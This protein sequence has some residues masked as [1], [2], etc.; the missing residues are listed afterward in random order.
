MKKIAFLFIIIPVF[1]Y[2]QCPGATAISYKNKARNLG[3]QEFSKQ[4]AYIQL[5]TYY[6]YKCEC[7]NG[8]PRSAQLV[9]MINSLVDTYSAYTKN[10]Y[11]T[12]SKVSSCKSQDGSGNSGATGDTGNPNASNHGSGIII[13][14][15]KTFLEE[16]SEDIGLDSN[17]IQLMLEGKNDEALKLMNRNANVSRIAEGFGG[18]E[19][20]A[21]QLYDGMQMTFDAI[22]EK[23]EKNAQEFVDYTNQ[24]KISNNNTSNSNKFEYRS[25]FFDKNWKF[26]KNDFIQ[27]SE[28]DSLKIS[29]NIKKEIKKL[30]L[31]TNDFIFAEFS[32]KNFDFFKDFIIEFQIGFNTEEV[33]RAI[34]ARPSLAFFISQKTKASLGFIN[35]SDILYSFTPRMNIHYGMNR[36][37]KMKDQ[38]FRLKN[39]NSPAYGTYFNETWNLEP[40]SKEWTKLMSKDFKN[41]KSI[42]QKIIKDYKKN[43]IDKIYLT[44]R[45]IKE[46]GKIYLEMENKSSVTNEVVKARTK[47]IEFDFIQDQKLFF[48]IAYP[49]DEGVSFEIR[50]FK[51]N[52]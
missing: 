40:W 35:H 24:F 31:K 18:D 41:K 15:K 9:S 30:E 21:N 34:L 3:P 52:Q 14:P 17:V 22:A 13:E 37:I 7:E 38:D 42:A 10:A 25:N 12:M 5:A 6:A 19:L 4:Q 33:K 2:S 16:L 46:N 48:G 47:S 23:W 39:F 8:S 27:I 44:Y 29:I 36:L 43:N 26:Y 1:S 49:L 51:I 20:L 45:L 11:G 32:N 28:Y 50:N